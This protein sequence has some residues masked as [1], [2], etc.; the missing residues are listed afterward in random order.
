M[1]DPRRIASTSQE[2]SRLGFFRPITRR[3]AFSHGLTEGKVRAALAAGGLVSLQPGTL[4]PDHVW[5]QADEAGRHHL[6]LES[7][8]LRHPSAIA[9]HRSAALLLQLPWNDDPIATYL[10]Q[11]LGRVAIVEL[12]QPGVGRRQPRIRLYPGIIPDDQRTLSLGMPGTSVARTCLDLALQLPP[13]QAIAILDVGLRRLVSDDNRGIDVRQ[14]VQSA[15]SRATATA[16]LAR[17]LGQMSARKGVAGLSTLIPFAD[18]AAESHLES[19]SRWQM[20]RHR[21]PPPRCGVPVTGDDGKTYWADFVWPDAKVIGEADGGVK[22]ETR[23]VLI[24]EKRR[25]ES[26]ERAGWLVIRWNWFEAVVAPT[27]MV[28]RIQEALGRQHRGLRRP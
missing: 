23:D 27:I 7:A 12:T 8:L 21:V 20:H 17:I 19:L 16:H 6:A 26:L 3:T 1:P 25:Q 22:Y 11:R 13:G 5:R 4:L 24:A 14:A 10:D 15:A 18:P 2:I 28:R 9:S